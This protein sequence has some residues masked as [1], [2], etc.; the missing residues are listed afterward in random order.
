MTTPRPTPRNDCCG[1][2]ARV[3]HDT[4]VDAGLC[5]DCG[6]ELCRDCA[7]FWED[8]GEITSEGGFR[9]AGFAQCKSCRAEYEYK[10]A[11]GLRG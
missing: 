3:W 8:D 7:G 9:W 6:E 1:S 2:P 11:E 5:Q 10:R 4:G